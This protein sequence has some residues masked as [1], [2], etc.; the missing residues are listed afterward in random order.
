MM[1]ALPFH[2]LVL[3]LIITPARSADEDKIPYHFYNFEAPRFDQGNLSGSPQGLSL[4]QGT[5]RIAAALTTPGPA[6]HSCSTTM[7]RTVR[8]S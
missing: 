4:V 3:L 6:Q 8:F 5:A 2:C 7:G 1:K